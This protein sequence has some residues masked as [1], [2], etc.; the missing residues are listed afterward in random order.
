[1]NYAKAIAIVT[2]FA[3]M[4]TIGEAAVASADA[5]HSS[6]A[7][8]TPSE[9]T[10]VEQ[11]GALSVTGNRI[12]DA[13][14]RA[15]ALSG[16]SHFWSNSNW[17]QEG[18]YTAEAVDYFADEWDASLFRAA[19]GVDAGGGYLED[20]AN[21][22]RTRKVID[23]AIEKGAYVLI[24]W[25]S[26]HAEDHPDEAVKFFTRMAEIYGDKPNVIYEIYNEP[27]NI[28]WS[29]TLKP[30]SEKVIAAI[31]K[32]DPD[33]LIIVGTPNWS[34]DVDV[35]AKD[36]IQGYNNI[37][38]TMHFYAG[39]HRE[40]LR[41]KTQAALDAGLAIF[42]TEWGA[43]NA[44]GDGDVDA[45]SVAEWFQFL[46]KNCLSSANWAVSTKKEGASIFKS[47]TPQTGPWTDRDLTASGK[48]VKG[49]VHGGTRI[50]G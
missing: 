19:M 10:P 28:S 48:L 4:G 21:E 32:V 37:A 2:A 11:F 24:D 35:A 6:S 12:T 17:G 23:A 46:D 47:S 42:V 5:P 25:H 30:Y 36:P 41:K 7:K 43:I 18:L 39:T 20:K 29:D 26:H 3:A 38:Y 31:R 40:E 15:I 49:I 33:N 16:V 1:M 22:V 34:Q 8:T 13:S 50:C 45:A 27:L 44:N 9:Q 14:G